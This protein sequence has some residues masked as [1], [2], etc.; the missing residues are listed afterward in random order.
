MG[1][2]L[3]VAEGSSEPPVL[4]E[5]RYTGSSERT[6]A[7]VGKGLFVYNLPCFDIVLHIDSMIMVPGQLYDLSDTPNFHLLTHDFHVHFISY[8]LLLLSSREDLSLLSNFLPQDCLTA[9]CT[10]NANIILMLVHNYSQ[11]LEPKLLRA[12]IK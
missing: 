7:I 6:V 3:G 1:C 2:F 11:S 5:M 9:L 4:V 10:K 12:S 8:L